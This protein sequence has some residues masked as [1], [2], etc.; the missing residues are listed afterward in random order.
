ME[1]VYY[2]S[3]K[4]KYKNHCL[5]PSN[6]PYSK[7]SMLFIIYTKKSKEVGKQ[8]YCHTPILSTFVI[9]KLPK[10]TYSHNDIVNLIMIVC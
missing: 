5:Q 7:S 6:C 4:T 8:K 2:L 9:A 10:L 3:V 1:T